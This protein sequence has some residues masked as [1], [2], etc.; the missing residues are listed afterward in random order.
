MPTEFAKSVTDSNVAAPPVAPSF[1]SLT[2]V[3][4]TSTVAYDKTGYAAGT[5]DSVSLNKAG[6]VVGTFSNGQNQVLAQV[7]LAAF[8]NP[9]G[10]TK[11]GTNTY[12]VS[13]NSGEPQV[14]TASTGG[15]GSLTPGAL[16]MSNVDLSSEFSSMIVTQRGF[17]ANSKIIT[18]SDEMLQTLVDMKR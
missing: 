9:G 17:Q 2:Q 12:A 8:N 18:V 13:A 16:E 6:E 5:L 10:L 1:T 4:G 3:A 7:A 11:L 14:G 15:R